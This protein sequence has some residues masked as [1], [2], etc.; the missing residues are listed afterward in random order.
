[1]V[2]R[3]LEGGGSLSLEDLARVRGLLTHA[4]LRMGLIVLT[5][6]LGFAAWNLAS[7]PVYRSSVKLRVDDVTVRRPQVEHRSIP[8]GTVD[9]GQALT[10]LR[11][12]TLIGDIVEPAADATSENRAEERIHLGLTTWVTDENAP[13]LRRILRS[14]IAPVH[15]DFRL[16]ATARRLSDTAPVAV[17]VRF[18]DQGAVSVSGISFKP[19]VE[20]PEDEAETLAYEPGVPVLY[21]GMELLLRVTGEPDGRVWRIEALTRDQ[22]ID[23]V[24]QRVRVDKQQHQ[25]GALAL[26]VL[27][28]DPLRAAAIANAIAAAFVESDLA[29]ARRDAV[30]TASFLEEELETRRAALDALTAEEADLQ[31]ANPDTID[32]EATAIDLSSRQGA[33]DDV[34]R[35]ARNRRILADRVELLIASGQPLKTALA[36]VGGDHS[37]EVRS[38]LEAL[39]AE[40]SQLRQVYRGSGDGG[41]RRTLLLK[42]DDYRIEAERFRTRVA[43]LR[44]IIERIESGDLTALSRLGGDLARDGS[45]AV[46]WSMRAWMTELETTRSELEALEAEF[47]DAYPPLIQ[48]KERM[49]YFQGQILGG[50]RA[51]LVGHEKTLEQ[52]TEYARAWSALHAAHPESEAALIRASIAQLQKETVAAFSAHTASLRLAETAAREEVERLRDRLK[53]LAAARQKLRGTQ[54]ETRELDRVVGDLVRDVENARVAIAGIVPSARIIDPATVP[55]GPLKPN[56][57][58]G[59]LAGLVLGV[60]AAA[61]WAWF[62]LQRTPLMSGSNHAAEERMAALPV[63]GRVAVAGPSNGAPRRVRLLRGGDSPKPSWLPMME[64]PESPAAQTYRTLRARLKH[65]ANAAGDPPRVLGVT[66]ASASAEVSTVAINLAMARAQLG[67]RILLVDGALNGPTLKATILS[68]GLDRADAFG[69]DIHGAIGARTRGGH[70]G[71]ARGLGECLDGTAHWSEVAAPSG[72]PTLDVLYTGDSWIVPAD[73]LASQMFEVFCHETRSVYDLVLISLPAVQ[74]APDAEAAAA[75]LDGILFV[76]SEIAP[77][78]ATVIADCVERLQQAGGH[79]IGLVKTIA[80]ERRR[81][82]AARSPSSGL[83]SSRQGAA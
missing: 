71:D 32:A 8:T 50:L 3:G 27:D 56:A 43:D 80:I 51:L 67:E 44:D 4:P 61:A 35:K 33:W 28:D 41:Y 45:I 1:M 17:R 46:D 58:F 65:M 18:V 59:L 66:S 25:T 79:V 16:E 22:A 40:E 36:A 23:R 38:L 34:Y 11:S 62:D 64:A 72:F 52:K 2:R 70:G 6:A 24:L 7:T 63:C 37:P 77:V 55:R 10:L 73:L 83:G 60:L 69:S 15:R 48:A 78:A 49:S 47:T 82:G 9:E 68:A 57:A 74:E 5:V 21:H 53:D 81:S 29:E 30:Q 54:L 31:R 76:E 14:T 20:W 39:D 75:S 42:A 19:G 26:T 13:P 12:R